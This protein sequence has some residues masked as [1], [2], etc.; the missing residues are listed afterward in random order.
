L[1]TELR[2]S[3]DL[4]LSRVRFDSLA[5]ARFSTI[6]RA[7]A[8]VSLERPLENSRLVL[9]AAGG[10]AGASTELPAQEFLYFGGP[11][12]APGYQYHELAA[13]GGGTIRLEWR[14]PIPAPSVSLGRFGKMPGQATLAPFVQGTFIRQ[15]QADHPSGGYTSLGL[16]VQPFFDLLRIQL[17]RGLRNGI[18]S[19]NIDVSRD[20]WG[21]L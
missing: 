8:T 18:W 2:I 3:G 5:T 1:G 14:L 19:L 4:R 11:F 17:A 16:A 21:I 20:Y 13:R 10:A 9:Y 15:A 7:F 12:S 6:G